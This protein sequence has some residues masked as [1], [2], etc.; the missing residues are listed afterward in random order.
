MGVGENKWRYNIVGSVLDNNGMPKITPYKGLNESGTEPANVKKYMFS[1]ENLAWC[2]NIKDLFEAEIGP[3]D[4]LTGK[5]GRIMWFPPYDISFSES[6]SVQNESTSF[7]GRGEPV[8]TYNNTERMG[9]LAFKIIIDHP[10][11]VNALSDYSNDE[12]A[13]FFAGCLPL[14][15]TLAN[16]LTTN[17]KSIVNSRETTQIQ[18]KVTNNEEP[19]KPFKIY[20]PNDIS[21][22]IFTKKKSGSGFYEDGMCDGSEVV[23]TGEGCGLSSPIDSQIAGEFGNSWP[24]NTNFGLNKQQYQL[25]GS[26]TIYSG[27]N[28]SSLLSAMRDYIANKC[29]TCKIKITGYASSQG[30]GA[31]PNNE[32]LAQ[33]RTNTVYNWLINNVLSDSTRY[34]T[35]NGGVTLDSGDEN[36]PVSSDKAKK[37]RF[38]KVEFEIDNELTTEA[39]QPDVLVK[40]INTTTV[41]SGIRKRFY[42]E[43]NFFEKLKLEDPIVY[44]EIKNKIK[45]FHPDFH[46]TTPE[47]FNA[48]LNFL[49]QCTRQ[50][51]TNIGKNNS[52]NNLAFGRPP[53]C[54][55]RIGDFYNT[56]IMIDNLGITYE[57]LVWDL[58]PEG[59]G[60]QPMIANVNIAFK[61]IGG[62]S[63]QGPI[64]KLQN[65]LS[66][67]FFANTQVYDRRSDTIVKANS[68]EKPY[69]FVNGETLEAETFEATTSQFNPINPVTSN[70]NQTATANNSSN[71][72]EVTGAIDEP[73]IVG[74]NPIIDTNIEYYFGFWTIVVTLKFSKVPTQ[75]EINKL[76]SDSKFQIVS[77]TD[78]S[79]FIEQMVKDVTPTNYSYEIFIPRFP[80][81]PNGNYTL[82]LIKGNL[83]IQ[84]ANITLSK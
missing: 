18:Q 6:S 23:L 9:N 31:T 48:R 26:S 81:F 46:S 80:P 53:V 19:P 54:I 25:P 12:M 64:N 77:L 56:K 78:S 38:V 71:S 51:Q 63:L 11:Y 47:G 32:T 55:L 22:E 84:S 75:D 79:L 8:Y 50:G 83:L 42:N 14:D 17:E 7:I 16:K 49:L 39:T 33:N 21:N 73:N 40:G 72:I 52:I 29:K 34:T 66:F 59:I 2:N 10:S 69:E 5:K 37:G 35:V 36:T 76:I 15:P 20:F 24:D 58:N 30:G 43:S 41:S 74:F 13:S 65:A 68:I 44:S 45:Y 28:D 1:I 61:F 3:G 4:L 57:P 82:K 62:S 70:I 27:M 60:V 67:N